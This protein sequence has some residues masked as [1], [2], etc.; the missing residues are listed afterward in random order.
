[1]T[2]R[3]AVT[4]AAAVRQQSKGSGF[5][6]NKIKFVAGDS[7]PAPGFLVD[8]GGG[9]GRRK[10]ERQYLGGGDIQDNRHTW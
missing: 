2:R 9:G 7:I 5:K 3:I 10:E 4:S 6:E 8:F 1:M